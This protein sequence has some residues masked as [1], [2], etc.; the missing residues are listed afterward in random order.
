[1]IA[2]KSIFIMAGFILFLCAS[3]LMAQTSLFEYQEETIN[4]DA[5]SYKIPA[6]V[7]MPIAKN[8]DKFPVVIM[9][10]GYGSNKDE[11]GDGYK[12][13]AP[14]L[15]KKGIA[16]IRIDFMGCGDSTVDHVNFDLNVGV[17]EAIAAADFAATL[18]Q[19]NPDK[20]GIMGW[21]KGGSIA[22]LAAGRSPKFKS[23]VTWAGAPNLGV[24]Y[25][26]ESYAIAK[27]DGVFVATFEWREPL[28]M[29]LKAFEVAAETDI[30]KVF[31]GSAAP[32]LAINGSDDT[33]VPPENASNIKEASKN[34]DSQLLL[35]PGADHTFNI[36]TGDMAAFNTL[37]DATIAWFLKTL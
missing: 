16:S 3:G 26:S 17:S 35:I 31:S 9:L 7:T 5:E 37:R 15:A 8:S 12:L 14:E 10:H 23:V 24:V 27:R 32:V 19:I 25:D 21:S 29:S 36:F 13:I 1:M 20:I 22:L 34:K 4:I 28:K 11:A 18:S 30:L 33:V 2:K 6:V